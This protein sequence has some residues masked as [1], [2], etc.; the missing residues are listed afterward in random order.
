MD[1]AVLIDDDAYS[2]GFGTVA[3]M[4]VSFKKRFGTTPG[5]YRKG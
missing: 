5:N 4:M 1:G 3:A 2:S